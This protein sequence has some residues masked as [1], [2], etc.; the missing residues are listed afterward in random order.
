M[1]KFIALILILSLNSCFQSEGSGI[2]FYIENNSDFA[3]TDVKFTTSENLASKQ[4][5]IIEPNQG[6]SDFLSMKENVSDGS[7][8]LEFTR[9]NGKRDSIGAGYYTN[10]GALDDKLEF[11]IQNDTIIKIFSEVLY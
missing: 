6:V 9:Y 2:E 11:K 1:R 8:V 10:G 5:E 7:Y 4:F 3:I